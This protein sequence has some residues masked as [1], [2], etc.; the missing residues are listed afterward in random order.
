MD[1]PDP[2]SY[3]GRLA[4][5][6][7]LSNPEHLVLLDVG[8]VAE[9]TPDDQAHLVQ[10]FKVPHLAQSPHSACSDAAFAGRP[11]HA[12]GKPRAS[13]TLLC[14]CQGDLGHADGSVG[15]APVL[16]RWAVHCAGIVPQ[17]RQG[18]GPEHPRLLR[19]E[20]HVPGALATASSS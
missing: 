15:S 4:Q 5:R 19:R 3:W 7:D 11:L 14:E 13:T 17:G 8:M 10:F 18:A 6:L 2:R 9:L 12:S 16:Q 20:A 1:R